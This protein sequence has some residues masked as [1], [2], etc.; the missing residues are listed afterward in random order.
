MA[1][2]KQISAH[3]NQ[4]RALPYFRIEFE[5]GFID[6]ISDD[7]PGYYDYFERFKNGEFI[8]WY[9]N[10]FDF[11]AF[12]AQCVAGCPEEYLGHL[13]DD[14]KK[15][16]ANAASQSW[17]EYIEAEQDK[18]KVIGRIWEFVIAQEGLQSGTF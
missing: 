18:D 2:V 3:K 7:E 13:T 6:Y 9:N 4:P 16:W 8:D 17:T 5:S 11:D 14:E 12:E 1:Q 15:E 10:D